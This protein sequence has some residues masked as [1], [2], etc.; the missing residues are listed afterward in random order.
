MYKRIMDLAT[1]RRNRRTETLAL[2]KLHRAIS[3]RIF[4]SVARA[5]QAPTAISTFLSNGS[6][7]THC[8]IMSVSCKISR[9]FSV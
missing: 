4:G 5:N 8:S 9:T 7:V 3:I 2:A 1:I 6:Q